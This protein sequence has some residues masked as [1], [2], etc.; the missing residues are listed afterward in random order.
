[1]L[2]LASLQNPLRA[3]SRATGSTVASGALAGQSGYGFAGAADEKRDDQTSWLFLEINSGQYKS[4][5]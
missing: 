3:V 4:E 2:F 1:M 5:T